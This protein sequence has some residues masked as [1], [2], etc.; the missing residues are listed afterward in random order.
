M[1]SRPATPLAIT[2]AIMAFVCAMAGA[3]DA[4]AEGALRRFQEPHRSSDSSSSDSSS[5]DSTSS[6]SS[7]KRSAA[8]E[9]FGALLQGLFS[10][11]G[12]GSSGGASESTD[13]EDASEALRRRRLATTIYD[14]ERDG[15]YVK[16]FGLADDGVTIERRNWTRAGELKASG[17]LALNSEVV[18][19]DF[20][21]NG[22][23]GLFM[24]GAGYE[25]FYEPNR[26]A[27]SIDTL[28][29]FRLRLG[30]NILGASVKILELYV[31]GGASLMHGFGETIPALDLGIEGR[32]YPMRPLTFFASGT[33]S[34]YKDGPPIVEGRAE[35]GVSIGRVD[36]RAGFRAIRQNPAQSFLGP[37][38]SVVVRL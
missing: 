22:F 31:L 37:V 30:P 12:G 9:I 15:A 34:F 28:D 8:G 25:R 23:L 4:R 19:H 20:N 38:A 36:L 35:G 17:F 11:G 16:P 1:R 14:D 24:L 13:S 2:L 5:S 27:R 18:A 10:G 6:S 32:A 26:A 29:M 21:V 7:S 3:A 33:S